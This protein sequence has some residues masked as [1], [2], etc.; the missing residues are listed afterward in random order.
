LTNPGTKI[1]ARSRAR[2]DVKFET[3][4]VDTASIIKTVTRL[5][6]QEAINNKKDYADPC[7]LSENLTTPSNKTVTQS[8]H[9]TRTQTVHE[10]H[11]QHQKTNFKKKK[12]RNQKKQEAET[13]QCFASK[14]YLSIRTGKWI[15]VTPIL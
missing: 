2:L 1:S 8:S 4:T 10:T 13:L 6:C 5:P 7:L 12:P 14:T 15:F 11:T 3:C 9:L